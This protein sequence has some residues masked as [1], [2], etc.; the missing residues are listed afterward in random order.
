M[1]INSTYIQYVKK[2]QIV[3]LKHNDISELII[4]GE[5][6]FNTEKKKTLQL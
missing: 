1:H 3:S 4:H 2:C 5:N 6:I